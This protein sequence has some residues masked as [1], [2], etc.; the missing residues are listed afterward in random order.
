[1]QIELI[2]CTSAGKSRL[3][4]KILLSSFQYGFNLVTSYDFVL[5]WAHLAWIQNHAIRMLFLNLIAISACLF[6]WRKNLELYRFVLGVIQRLPA[7]VHLAERIKIARIAARNVG[8][9]EI[10]RRYNSGQQVVLA[11]EGTLHIANYLFVHVSVEP[12][13]NDLE[14]FVRL[15]SLPDVAVYIRQSESV[16]IARTRARKHKRIPQ[17]TANLVNR[18]IQHSLAVFESLV[19]CSSLES[20]LLVVNHGKCID[21]ARDFSDNSML[22]SA[23]RIIDIGIDPTNW[24]KLQTDHA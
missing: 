7:K 14:T 12:D 4:N 5:R 1:M 16:L 13:L 20:R 9:D 10:V 6:T 21:A 8:I 19:A 22:E 11:D 2:G 3:T 18:F 15:V 24:E 23:R 17:G